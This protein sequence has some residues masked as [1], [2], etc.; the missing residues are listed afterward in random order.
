MATL[1][2]LSSIAGYIVM[3]LF[4]FGYLAAS[5]GDSRDPMN[6]PFPFF[7]CVF[8]PVILPLALLG[9]NQVHLNPV[10]LGLSLGERALARKEKLV[11]KRQKIRVEFE[12][13]EREL[14]RALLELDE[15][16]EQ[17]K[18]SIKAKYYRVM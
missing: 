14:E 9:L 16:Q 11:E 6:H 13:R 17:E 7:G 2:I 18:E 5:R 8:W 15:E 3:T 4:T 1:I 12:K 10:Q